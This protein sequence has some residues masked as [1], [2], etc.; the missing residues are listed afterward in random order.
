MSDAAN[1]G[2]GV[3]YAKQD[4]LEFYSATGLES[5]FIGRI[6]RASEAAR[7]A[8]YMWFSKGLCICKGR[9]RIELA[10][11]FTDGDLAEALR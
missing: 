5:D 3:F 8:E 6:R 4:V 11:P 9:L 2:G 10:Y 1:S 7:G